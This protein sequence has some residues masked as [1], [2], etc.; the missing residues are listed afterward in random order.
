RAGKDE[1]S[2]EHAR[3]YRSAGEA[4]RNAGAEF[5][6]ICSNTGHRRADE[7]EQATGLEV[8]HIA[9]ATAQAVKAAGH[10][11]V[12]LLGTATTMQ[13]PFIRERIE[14]RWCI[15]VAVPDA[16]TRDT[17]DRLIMTEMVNGIFSDQARRFIRDVIDQ[18]G[19]DCGAEALILGCT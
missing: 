4:L 6:V 17:L 2:G 5:I 18:M 9:D 7:I 8:L 13:S 19:R 12:A 10:R 14:T 16:G 11:R 1:R 3:I 15:E